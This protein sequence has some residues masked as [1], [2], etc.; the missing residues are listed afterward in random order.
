MLTKERFFR[1]LDILDN[2]SF[3]T[4]QELMTA[5]QTSKSTINR[6]LIELEKQ[7]LVQ[8]ERGGAIKKELPA[9]LSSYK[10]IPVIDKEFIHSHEKEMIC[11]SAA[12]VIREGDCIY[13]DS[14]TTP[15]YLI[16]FIAQKNIKLVTSSIYAVRKL[17]KNYQAELFLIGGKYNMSYDMSVG[18]LTTENIKRFHFDHAF[19]SASGVELDT[20]EVM[21]VDFDIS[22]VKAAVMA[23]TRASHLLIDDSKLRVKALCT[24][25]YLPDFKNIFMNRTDL[26]IELPDNFTQVESAG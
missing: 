22:E 5:L 8:R 20:G 7:G 24:W 23:R 17:P 16:P 26:D 21:A 11:A 14:G 10:E 13:I 15:S 6:D 2:K 9:T 12:E 1:I 3:V 18:F 4:I 19:F 25:A